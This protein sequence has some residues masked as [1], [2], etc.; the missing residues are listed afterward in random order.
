MLSLRVLAN[1]RR[2]NFR[3]AVVVSRKVNKS[4][5]ARNRLRRRLYEQVRL[6]AADIKAYDLVFTVFSDQL[7]AL[8]P[9]ELQK[10]VTDL[11]QRANVLTK[12]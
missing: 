8:S 1:D 3:V 5:V 10:L 11:L 7:E 9:T 12:P 6:R 4:A 2:S